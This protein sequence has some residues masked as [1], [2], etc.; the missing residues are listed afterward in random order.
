MS[1]QY[2]LIINTGPN[3]GKISTS[4]IQPMNLQRS[5]SFKRM[6]PFLFG[7]AVFG[8][9]F[10]ILLSIRLDLFNTLFYDPENISFFSDS[11]V[12]DRDSWMNIFQNGRKI[13][14]S[15]T[16]F[17][18][19]KTGYLLKEDI[20]MRINTMGL[21]QDI[22]LNTGGVLNPDFTLSSFDFEIS[23]GR[24]RFTA[25]GTVSDDVLSIKTHSLG[26]SRKI[27]IRIKEKLYVAAGILD[28]VRALKLEPGDGFTFQVFDP[29]TMG[30]E[31]VDIKVIG[32]EEILN[33]GVKK[34]AKK[35]EILFKGVTQ[36]AWIGEDG[37]VL[38]ETGLLGISLE[39]TT[40]D[41]ALFGLPVT[42]SQDL[43]KIASVPSNVAID[44]TR[45]LT[46]LEVEIKGINYQAVHL[47]GGRQ[48]LNNN[49][50]TI[51]KETL[52]NLPPV[53]NMTIMQDTEMK[54]LKPTPFVQSDHPK[55][56]NLAN[57]ILSNG[58]E[59]LQRAGELVV[60]V[61]K[62][63]EKRPV[64]SMPDALSTLENRV[65]DCN[66]HAVLLA[67]LA[68]AAGIPAR[69]EAG[70]VYLNGRFYYHAWNLLY[71]GKWITMDSLFNQIPADVTHIRFSSGGQKEQL[72]LMSIMGKIK[73]KIINVTK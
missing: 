18:K 71:V 64:L 54:F 40:R 52:S 13:G 9:L 73:L 3:L 56:R 72:D 27:D 21:V 46:R 65:G 5:M 45:M 31:S 17:S 38:R 2:D 37:D 34:R 69:I 26:A 67:A 23:S 30:Q 61:Y 33:M 59:P 63:I 47:D 24:F 15:H 66:E 58:G 1:F 4:L 36:L 14:S 51:R 50:L 25:K 42:S 16:T 68:R 62:N 32:K 60:W 28:S 29:A 49:V 22:N 39:K 44:D 6:K 53:F 55:I 19:T 57:K 10:A 70:L 12:I 11:A 35:I 48:T 20:Y 7:L 8:L 41:N 43:T